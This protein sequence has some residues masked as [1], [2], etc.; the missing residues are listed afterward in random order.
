MVAQAHKPRSR[1][2]ESL[3]KQGIHMHKACIV[4]GFDMS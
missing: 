4:Q 2:A 3:E 1:E